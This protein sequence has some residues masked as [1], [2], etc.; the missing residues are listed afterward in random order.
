MAS[1]FPGYEFDV[2]ISYR[3]KDNKGDQWGTNF[4]KFNNINLMINSSIGRFLI[5]LAIT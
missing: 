3:Q 5:H 2:F 4:K 1:F